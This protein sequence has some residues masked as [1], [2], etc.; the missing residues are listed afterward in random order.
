M[1]EADQLRY[2]LSPYIYDMARK[3][4]D[5]GVSI[6]RPMYYE[7]PEAENAYTYQQQ[8][9]FGDNILAA[10]VCEPIDS[11]SG[12]AGRRVWF[13]AGNDWYDMAH[14]QTVKGG[15]VRDLRYTIGEICWFVKAGAII[16]LAEEGIQDLQTPSNVLRIFIAP[17]AGKSSYIHYEDDGTSQAYPDAYATTEISKTATGSGVTVTV[18]A[19]RGSYKGM[20]AD[21]DLSIILGGVMRQPSATLGGQ[22][23]ACTYDAATREAT[24]KLPVL[25]SSTAATIAIKY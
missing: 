16:P 15:S 10:T 22:A 14:K 17:G 3:A 2:A 6:C 9:Y 19:R 23:L 4:Y 24:I 20:S 11:L 8:Y 5:T 25:P 13:P 21:R 18:G 12:T 1:L 7:S